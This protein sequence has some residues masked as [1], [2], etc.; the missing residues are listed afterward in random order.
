LAWSTDWL[1]SANRRNRIQEKRTVAIFYFFSKD[2]ECALSDVV[3]IR[4]QFLTLV[5]RQG[6]SFSQ[7]LTWPPGVILSP[8]VFFNPLF[9][10]RG[11][12]SLMFRR[13]K[14]RTEGF[15]P[16]GPTSPLRENITPGG[17]N[18]NWPLVTFCHRLMLG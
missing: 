7:G 11:K 18:K 2:S 14:G 15:H 9:T 3:P 17:E 1:A 6:W 10:P 12:H 13:M 16:W 8:R 4:G 5:G